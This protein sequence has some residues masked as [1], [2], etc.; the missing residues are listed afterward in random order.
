MGFPGIFI[1]SRSSHITIIQ[2]TYS[3][4]RTE[5]YIFATQH[6]EGT[7]SADAGGFVFANLQNG[8]GGNRCKVL[9]AIKF[10][11]QS[12]LMTVRNT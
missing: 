12:D 1:Y 5:S 2:Y 7:F 4:S 6:T 9:R 10:Y 8:V 11:V 3:T